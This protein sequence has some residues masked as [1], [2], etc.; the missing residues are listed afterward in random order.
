[1]KNIE[2]I[3]VNQKQIN[4]LM[5]EYEDLSR[6]LLSC[7]VDD[8]MP[9][10][11]KRERISVII[12]GLSNKITELCSEDKTGNEIA[13]YKNSCLRSDLPEEM[14]PIFDLRQ[15]FN[16]I[17]FRVKNIDAEATERIEYEKE[18]LIKKIKDNNNGQNA[19]ASKFLNGGMTMG[20]DVYFPKKQ[21]II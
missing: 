7:E 16:S 17:A 14:L 8:I 15:E 18:K 10:I 11:Q 4:D 1:M 2:E 5:R 9:V 20:Q 12:T 13:A 6:K 3:T 21:K 19:K